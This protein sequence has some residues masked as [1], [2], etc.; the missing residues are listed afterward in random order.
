MNELLT[1]TETLRRL[2]ETWIHKIFSI[3]QAH[4]GTRWLNLWKINQLLS[5]GQDAGLINAMEHWAIKLSVYVDNPQAIKTALENLPPDPPNLPQFMELVR[6]SSMRKTPVFSITSQI[7]AEQRRENRKHVNE[8]LT[9]IRKAWDKKR[10]LEEA[11]RK[12]KVNE[13][14]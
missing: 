1:S 8:C 11:G 12:N 3:M 13:D 5:D 4:Y 14:Y 2:P 7:N 10:H 6:Q 9:I